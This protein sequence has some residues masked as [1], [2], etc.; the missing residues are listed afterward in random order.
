MYDV[1]LVGQVTH[2]L[3]EQQNNDLY[4]RIHKALIP[5]GMLLLDVPMATA[6]LDEGSSFLSLILWANSGG[7]AYSFEEYRS[8][9]VDSGFNTIHQLSERLLSAVR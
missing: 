6:Q 5:G 2:Y 7:R 8:W 9:L 3:T 1:C 4:M